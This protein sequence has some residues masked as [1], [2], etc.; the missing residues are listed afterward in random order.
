MR[1]EHGQT[2]IVSYLP[3]NDRSDAVKNNRFVETDNNKED[4]IEIKKETFFLQE[5]FNIAK[6]KELEISKK[7][8]ELKEKYE[9]DEYT[10]VGKDIVQ[11]LMEGNK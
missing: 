4:A 8:E 11:K 10:V 3:K 1:I 6:T 9:E 2:F 5:M 7:A